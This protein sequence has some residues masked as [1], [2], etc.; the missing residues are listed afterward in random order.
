M[1]AQTP[2]PSV[3]RCQRLLASGGASASG[4]TSASATS[5]SVR[6]CQWLPA[7]GAA[8]SSASD[9]SALG[10]SGCSSAG[11]LEA[12]ATAEQS[13]VTLCGGAVTVAVLA[14]ALGVSSWRTGRHTI[15]CRGW[16]GPTG[17]CFRCWRGERPPGC[18]PAL[19]VA[20]AASAARGRMACAATACAATAAS[21]VDRR[22]PLWCSHVQEQQVSCCG[23]SAVECEVLCCNAGC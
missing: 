10:A 21:T 23:G 22:F 8:G 20:R 6:R 11:A 13:A 5:A 15:L 17:C 19:D 16:R 2:S 3:R 18:S 14:T 7:L 9:T 4:A 12:G 1:W